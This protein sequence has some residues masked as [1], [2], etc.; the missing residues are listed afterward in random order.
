M[1]PIKD[2]TAIIL[3]GG[4]SSRMGKDKVSL[5]LHEKPLLEHISEALHPLFSEVL[6]SVRKHRQDIVLKQICDVSSEHAPLIGLISVLRNVSSSW[7]FLTG[8]DMPWLSP[9][10]IEFL[11]EKRRAYDAVTPVVSGKIQPLF[12]FYN[13]SSLPT[14]EAQ[15]HKGRLSLTCALQCLNSLQVMEQ[16]LRVFDPQ[17]LSFSDLDTPE[18]WSHAVQFFQKTLHEK[19]FSETNK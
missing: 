12:A 10:A 6:V 15:L 4:D 3:A 14:L 8:C 11:G 1:N 5:I 18:D 17:L 7:V 9:K 16:E 2:C 19:P 13:K